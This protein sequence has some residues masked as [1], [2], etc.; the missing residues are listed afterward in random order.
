MPKSTIRLPLPSA[1]R[2]IG[3]Y[4]V[5]R[6]RQQVRSVAF[7]VIYMVAFQLLIFGRAPAQALT[8]AGGIALVVVGLAFLL[9]G[10]LLGLMPLARQ[11]GLHLSARGGLKIILPLGLLLGIASTLAEPAVAALRA[12]G[13][14]IAAWESPLLFFLL[15]TNPDLL[16]LA[17]AI[18][19]G[20][21]VAIG[22]ARFYIGFA[23]KP[24]I[25]LSVGL[26]V[27]A[28]LFCSYSDALAPILGLAWDAGAVTT[29]A[30]TVSVVLAIGIGLS[31][32]SGKSQGAGSSFGIIM[33][34]SA[35]PVLAVIILGMILV[36]RLP[37]PT[38]ATNFFSV[39]MR[40][41]V[42][43]LFEDEDAFQ[44]YAQEHVGAGRQVEQV[45]GAPTPI[46]NES[47]R[48]TTQPSLLKVLGTESLMALRA[49]LPL[50]ALL[51]IVLLFLLRDRPRHP[52]EIVI[53]IVFA[54]VG[55]MLLTTGIRIG[56][57]QLGNDV[58]RRLPQVYGEVRVERGRIVVNNFD[59]AIVFKAATPEGDTIEAFSIFDGDTFETVTYRPEWY[60]PERKIYIHQIHTSPLTHPVLS[61]IGLLL[62]LLFAFG[63]GY[64]ATIA[65]PALNALGKT[66]EEITVGTTKSASLVRAVAVGVGIGLV[67]GV[68]R[69]LY[70]LPMVWM[71][72]PPYLLLI[73]LTLASDEDFTGIAW[74]SGGV[75]T[76][77]VT[78]PLVMAMGLGLGTQLD[79]V[80]G[81]GILAMAAAYTVVTVH[82][83][84]LIVLVRQ[85]RVARATAREHENG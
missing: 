35:L 30:V 77:S 22:M 10:L 52:D 47:P 53:G 73:P 8:I 17:I 5:S 28:S 34:A 44:D 75:T 58:G 31:R 13:G 56:L 70:N 55:M 40:E 9:E 36:P 25:L 76:G 3:D 38:S 19:V 82:I 45:D 43:P 72:L 41:Q 16:I 4:F 63:M 79:I 50:A 84:G 20:V 2:M 14:G 12:V 7:I 23:L 78:V 54:F 32:S 81:F 65:E 64:G 18:G 1:L 59:P 39:E 42:L 48:R 69:I 46:V 66:V 74:D 67:L 24:V 60:D 85:R 71:I 33:L 57:S 26:L 15:Q 37:A 83:F 11:V 62:I 61:Q 49:V 21:A 29:G 6:L 80:D 51:G 27:V 68:I